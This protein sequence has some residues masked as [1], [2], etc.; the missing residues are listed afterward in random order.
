MC[1]M[2]ASKCST[3]LLQHDALSTV[4]QGQLQL[5]PACVFRPPVRVLDGS[6]RLRDP[7]LAIGEHVG[8]VVVPHAGRARRRRAFEDELMGHF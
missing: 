8:V 7:R 1:L 2:A 3:M 6:G 5:R 4:G